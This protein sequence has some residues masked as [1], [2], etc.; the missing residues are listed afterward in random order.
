VPNREHLPLSLIRNAQSGNFP[1]RDVEI[2]AGFANNL[3]NG[4][5]NT[6]VMQVQPADKCTSQSTRLDDFTGKLLEQA[7]YLWNF[8][9]KMLGHLSIKERH[10]P[11]A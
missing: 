3:T 2:E 8:P 7:C 11:A 5:G 1:I 4:L 10:D 9:S 6:G